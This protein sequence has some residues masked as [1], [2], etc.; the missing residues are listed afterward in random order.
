MSSNYAC[1]GDESRQ[2]DQ[3]CT[4]GRSLF[5]R[6]LAT[7]S[8]GNISVRIPTGSV[9]RENQQTNIKFNPVKDLLVEPELTFVHYD[10][11]NAETVAGLLRFE[12]RF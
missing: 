10:L 3:I 2:R 1:H 9:P 7:G 4:I 6:G 12:R 5:E 11:I 8:S